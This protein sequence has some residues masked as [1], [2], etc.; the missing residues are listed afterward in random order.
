MLK[1]LAKSFEFDESSISKQKLRR[2][3]ILMILSLPMWPL[4]MMDYYSLLPDNGLGTAALIV[5]IVGALSM[6]GFIS[7]RFVNRFYFGDKYLDEWEIRIKHK[8]MA[9]TF[10]VMLWI[11]FPLIF[12]VINSLNYIPNSA[13][14]LG[15]WFL[16]FWLTTLY[17][18]TF[19]A[20]WQVRPID[21][22]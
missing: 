20:L 5:M 3:L 18:Q 17:I 2:I 7:T 6:L 11:I 14:E 9:F 8:S 10:M 22:D 12:I 4:F 15:L 13:E 1:A 16:G 21:H 19:H